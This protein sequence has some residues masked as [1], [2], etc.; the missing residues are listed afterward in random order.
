[1]ETIILHNYPQSPAAEKVRV[2]LG[3]KGLDWRSVEIPRIP[4]KP[5]LMPLTGGYRRTPVMQI[6]AD[7]YC[8]SQCIQRELER[9]FPKPT[10]FPDGSEGMTWALSRW[11]DGPLFTQAVQLVLGAASADGNLPADFGAD[12]G[13]LY[14][15]PECDWKRVEADVPHIAAQIRGQFVWLDRWLALSGKSYL[16]GRAP[17]MADALGYHLVW[18][19]RGRWSG[20]PKMLSEFSRLEGWEKRVQAI[21]HGNVSAMTGAEAL[22]I[23]EAA[24]SQTPERTDTHDPQGLKPGMRVEVTPLG[25]GGDPAV[26]GVVRA[27]GAESLA[28]ERHDSRVGTVCVHFPRVGSRVT[29]L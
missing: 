12:R 28:I 18:F 21:G 25:D 8:D 7:I 16:A 4:P 27:A 11:V 23:A 14:V 2:A 19:I 1:M 22:D 20:G 26:V 15:G 17:G 24:E 6:G 10:F 3:I 5:D 29:V 9:R 13:R